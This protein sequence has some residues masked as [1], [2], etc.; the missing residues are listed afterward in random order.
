MTATTPTEREIRVYL[1]DVFRAGPTGSPAYRLLDEAMGQLLAVLRHDF[2][3]MG[4][5]GT[6][7]SDAFDEILGSA[8]ID[9]QERARLLIINEVARAAAE[10]ARQQPQAPLV[11][12]ELAR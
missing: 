9:T 11:P 12:V 5:Y 10:F 6:P 8:A 3:H 4:E 1:E 7:D 2:W